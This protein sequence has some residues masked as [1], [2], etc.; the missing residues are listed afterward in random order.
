[1][2]GYLNVGAISSLN[3]ANQIFSIFQTLIITN[4]AMV[5]YPNIIKAMTI[6]K[7]KAKKELLYFCNATNLFIIPFVFGFAGIGDILVKLIYG[8]GNF[9]TESV[10]QVF[11]LAA[12][13]LCGAPVSIIRDYMYKFFYG[14]N[15][16]KIP[17]RNSMVVLCFST[18]FSILLLPIFAIYALVIGAFLA[19]FIS[20]F[21][22]YRKLV[23][24]F[25]E[26]DE[27]QLFVK[28]HLLFITSSMIMLGIIYACRT[29]LNQF[30]LNEYLLFILL[31]LIG[32][33]T[34]FGITILI[35]KNMLNQF[36]GRIRN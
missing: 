12:I 24:T 35:N 28:Q 36:M 15:E 17:T 29:I 3:Y 13:I 5:M 32:I 31:S 9:S 33:I 10:K 21:L 4:V 27:M 11:L 22:I 6:S 14:M 25:G 26:L 19:N 23:R 1:M 20:C 18:T 30:N 16:T 8:R 2:A 34:Y 7:K